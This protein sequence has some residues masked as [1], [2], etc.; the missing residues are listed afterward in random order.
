MRVRMSVHMHVCIY[1]QL[2]E[3]IWGK[4]NNIVEK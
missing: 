4:G 3:S 2:T 1:T